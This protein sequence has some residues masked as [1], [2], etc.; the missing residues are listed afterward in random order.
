MFAQKAIPLES[1]YNQDSSLVGF[2]DVNDKVV[3]TPQFTQAPQQLEHI[4]AVVKEDKAGKWHYHYMLRSGKILGR[5]SMYV[6]DNGF[7]CENE[8]FIR[9]TTKDKTGLF[10]RHGAV[11]IPAEY[12][13]LTR[14]MNGMVVSL[15]GAKKVVDGEHYFWD[16]GTDALLDTANH[17]LIDHFTPSQQIDLYSV[18]IEN[19]KG[20]DT[21]REYFK[22]TNGKWYSFIVFEK[23]FNAWFQK[24]I[25]PG[26][27]KE[28][29]VKHSMPE[30]TYSDPEATWITQPK[31]KFIGKNPKILQVL[32][33][34]YQLL[35]EDLNPFLFDPAKYP[36]YFNNCF[37]AKSWQYPVM[38]VLIDGNQINFLKTTDGYKLVLVGLND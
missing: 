29:L 15:K 8:G 12:S 18:K 22:G 34:P 35:I 14:V 30:I 20:T 27:T 3:Y 38:L 4:M 6:F 5:D 25:L 9:F 10:N 13:S 19:N 37:T 2:K 23:E 17:V 31:E 7:D 16:G 26:L 36:E 11:A 32:S 33:Q 24:E 28:N 1:F 21:L